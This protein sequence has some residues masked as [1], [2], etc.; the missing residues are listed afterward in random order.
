M[1]ADMVVKLEGKGRGSGIETKPKTTRGLSY[2]YDRCLAQD[3]SQS[4]AR[5]G[6]PKQTADQATAVGSPSRQDVAIILDRSDGDAKP[7][8]ADASA[9][10]WTEK[11]CSGDTAAVEIS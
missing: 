8:S 10:I 5:C 11:T 9:T 7:V 3:R 6:F 4:S 2:N 1:F